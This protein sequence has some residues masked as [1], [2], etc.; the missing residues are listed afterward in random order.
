M[1]IHLHDVT[2]CAVDCVT[3]ALAADAL[4]KSSVGLTYGDVFLLTDT[5]T[6]VDVPI[7][8]IP[9]LRSR[10]AYS[11]FILRNLVEFVQTSHV[12][13]VQWDGFVLDPRHWHPEFLR[14][15]Y[16]G[17]QWGWFNDGMTVGNGG[18]SLRSR[19]LLEATAKAFEDTNIAANE[20]VLIC[21]EHR[22]WLE[23]QF[24][25]V[26]ASPAMA[27]RFSY[28]RTPP[29]APTFGF[30]GMFN[31]WR[32]F[33]DNQLLD[34][35][36]SLPNGT[37]VGREYLELL[38]KCLADRRYPATE[39]MYRRLSEIEPPEETEKR[40]AVQLSDKTSGRLIMSFLTSLIR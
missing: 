23:Q 3:P 27:D 8:T 38:L 5:T 32:H 22:R 35:V 20:D 19:K 40:I 6:V 26:F 13:I 29:A 14:V 28:E 10:D 34:L 31:F 9:S 11:S 17:A 25:I 18:F 16:I 30:H 4:Q 1:N 36:L 15:D 21:R 7:R 33:N 24:N 2:L 12:L 37:L 39:G